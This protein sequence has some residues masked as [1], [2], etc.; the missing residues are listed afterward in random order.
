MVGKISFASISQNCTRGNRYAGYGVAGFAGKLSIVI[1]DF[2]YRPQTEN[3][4]LALPA[5]ISLPSFQ[6]APRPRNGDQSA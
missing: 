2:G 1:D 6:C 3:Q 5:T 4:V